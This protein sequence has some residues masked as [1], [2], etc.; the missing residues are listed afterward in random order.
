MLKNLNRTTAL[1]PQIPPVKVLQFGKGNFL[2]AF[3]DWMV[4]IANEKGDFSG[5]IQI[6]QTN[7]REND[8]RFKEQEGLYHVVIRGIRQGQIVNDIRLITSVVG[9]INPFEEYE[10][11][12]RAGE[13]PD[14]QFIISN[15]TEAGIEFNADD[16]DPAVPS[17]SFPGKLTALLH[18]RYKF[19]EGKVKAPLTILPC[20]LTEGN[21]ESLLKIVLQY[22]DYWKLEKAFKSWIAD[23]VL[24]CNTLVDRIVPGFPKDTI[25]EITTATGFADA[26][27]VSAEPY[28]LWLIEPIGK[29]KGGLEHFNLRTALPLEQAGLN[30]KVVEALTPYR[31]RKV[32]ILNGAHTVMVPVA[33]LRGL[34]TVRDAIENNSVGD[35]V[36]T[37][38]AQEII[39]TLDLPANE[40]HEFAADVIERFRN[41]S[42][43]HE[44]SSIALNSI[45]KFQ[46]RV[47]PSIIEYHKRKKQLPEKL[48]YALAALIVF[49]RGEWRGEATPLNDTPEVRSFFRE[50]WGDKNVSN[51]VRKVL[52]NCDLW[53]IDLTSIDG[54]AAK[55]EGFVRDIEKN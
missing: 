22:A 30:V 3:A 5:S 19:F 37:A 52:S 43:R 14:L 12:L 15:T 21:G 42:I 51:V 23:H 39:P 17:R 26:L 11:F 33:Y 47:L 32:R 6:V 4:D 20:E 31:T 46:V 40:L 34:R 18:H 49:Y 1:T 41:P 36:R 24:F 8:V 54:L 7:S 25:D 10:A 55:V 29:A 28:H 44:L 53:K 45:S 27:T 2:R 35:F 48:L 16:K 9:V 50:A 38:I 13:N